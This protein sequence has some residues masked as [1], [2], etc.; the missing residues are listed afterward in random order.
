[1][2]VAIEW[3]RLVIDAALERFAVTF[4]Q[5]PVRDSHIREFLHATFCEDEVLVGKRFVYA[6]EIVELH[7]TAGPR[8][9]P[10]KA[11]PPHILRGSGIVTHAMR[12]SVPFAVV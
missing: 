4:A 5:C 11:Y 8:F 1:M 3:G 12:R 6:A 2:I 9:I 10:V 7:V